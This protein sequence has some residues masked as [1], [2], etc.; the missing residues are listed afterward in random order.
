[1]KFF[2]MRGNEEIELARNV[3]VDDGNAEPEVQILGRFDT[4]SKTY[5]LGERVTFAASEFIEI[6]TACSVFA[7][8]MALKLPIV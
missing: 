7:N 3:R 6:A 2:Y 5:R 1:M 8:D 4:R